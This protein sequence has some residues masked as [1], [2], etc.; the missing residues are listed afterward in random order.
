MGVRIHTLAKEL[1]LKS[2][3]L[4]DLL[5][6]RGIQV[7]NHMSSVDDDMAAQLRITEMQ[8]EEPEEPEVIPEPGTGFL[9]LSGLVGLGMR[10]RVS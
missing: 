5:A 4:M 9:L 1:G 6:D 10:R 2:R 3:D 8:D 7:K